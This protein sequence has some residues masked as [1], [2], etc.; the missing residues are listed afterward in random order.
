MGAFNKERAFITAA[1]VILTVGLVSACGGSERPETNKGPGGAFIIDPVRLDKATDIFKE[2]ISETF[3]GLVDAKAYQ[4]PHAIKPDEMI[5][6][7]SPFEEGIIA[8][9]AGVFFWLDLEPSARFAH[10]T[11][12]VLVG[13]SGTVH[14]YERRFWPFIRGEAWWDDAADREDTTL[15][16]LLPSSDETESTAQARAASRSSFFSFFSSTA[17]ADEN[18]FQLRPTGACPNGRTPRHFALVI[19]GDPDRSMQRDTDNIYQMLLGAEYEPKSI[20]YLSP[21]SSRSEVD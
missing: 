4:Y 9:E 15:Q 5:A 8:P 6:S 11:R 13:D 3:E 20:Q 1:L 19:Q 10:D 2:Y 18:A 17:H 16:V 12:F 7:F 21:D 14:E